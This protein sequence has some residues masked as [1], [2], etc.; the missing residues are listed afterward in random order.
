MEKIK[1]IVVD[2]HSFII[3]GIKAMLGSEPDIEIIGSGSNGKEAIELN[4]KLSPDVIVM[5]ISMP[6]MNGID[7]TKEIK[8]H[9]KKVQILALT[10]HEDSEYIFQFFKAG[11]EGYLL[12]NSKK[13]EFIEAIRT[14]MTGNH[15]FSKKISHLMING[16][17]SARNPDTSDKKDKIPLTRR[18]VQIIRLIS[19]DLSNQ[20][21]ADELNLSLR[22]VETHRRNIMQKLNVKSVVALVRYAIQH[23]MID[24]PQE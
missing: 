15:Y 20:E 10:Q 11:G 5:D 1:I 6:E 4:R 17:L 8:S 23:N 18:E 24:L 14:L 13:E 19:N 7:A 2:D 12:K 3:D 9:N 21:I 22:T 16:F